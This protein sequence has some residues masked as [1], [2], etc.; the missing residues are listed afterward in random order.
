MYLYLGG[1]A[2]VQSDEI[3]ALFDLDTASLSR[4]TRDMLAMAQ[5]QDRVKVTTEELPKSFVLCNG[6]I[7][8]L[9]QPT[10]A[11]LKKRADNLNKNKIK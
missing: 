8:Y 10:T 3:I 7:L 9:C 11:T 6:G 2:V 1:A 5:H 4:R